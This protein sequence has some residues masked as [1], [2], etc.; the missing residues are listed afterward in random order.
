MDSF[1]HLF[2]ANTV[3]QK[4]DLEKNFTFL[5][6]S[7]IFWNYFPFHESKE[8][9]KKWWFGEKKEKEIKSSVKFE[10]FENKEK[11]PQP[12]STRYLAVTD[13][14]KDLKSIRHSEVVA[15]E[16]GGES[17]S[18]YEICQVESFLIDEKNQIYGS[19]VKTSKSGSEKEGESVKSILTIYSYLISHQEMVKWV[20]NVHSIWKK[21]IDFDLNSGHLFIWEFNYLEG[22][23]TTF[24]SH[25]QTSV[26]FENTFFPKKD[27]L[28][29]ELDRFKNEW[30]KRGQPWQFGI[31]LT[32]E[33]GTGKTR[34]LKCIAQYME[35]HLFL[36]SLSDNFKIDKLIKMMNGVTPAISLPCHQ[37]ILVFE[38]IAD[39]T[40][41]IS[42][43]NE[44][45][46]PLSEKDVAAEKIAFEKTLKKRR[47]FLSRF[48]PVVDGISERIGG[49]IIMT[50]N[51][52]ERI[53]PALL[54]PGRI[55]FHLHMEGGYD[56]EVTFQVLENWWGEKLKEKRWKDLKDE[57]DKKYNGSQIIQKC[58]TLSSEELKEEFF[59]KK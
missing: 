24:R 18:N 30:D 50:T 4:L 42:P 27:L 49:M 13:L 45:F 22:C 41:L 29:Q 40:N 12:R 21:K 20:E 11:P 52:V 17:I 10:L 51:F 54:R 48:L 47:E 33:K 32:G 44:K 26:S 8:R 15:Q 23:L 31:A 7:Y 25:N 19:V 28:I 58:R 55:D 37:F 14:I 5:L 46:V 34:I 53:D 35:R 9:L 16:R 39:Q 2:I 6:F 57:I 59:K 43:R 56:K 36:V 38:E 3:L 1:N